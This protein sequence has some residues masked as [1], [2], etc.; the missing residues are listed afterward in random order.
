MSSEY[1]VP[2]LENDPTAMMLGLVP[3]MRPYQERR[4]VIELVTACGK[5]HKIRQLLDKR[6]MDPHL[7]EE[8]LAALDHGEGCGC[9]YCLGPRPGISPPPLD[10]TG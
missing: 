2:P 6:A 1:V 7:R 3:D 5:L 10:I 4:E 9:Y 8:F